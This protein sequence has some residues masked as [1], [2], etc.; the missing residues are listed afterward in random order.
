MHSITTRT[1]THCSLARLPAQ[2][3]RF[4]LPMTD[5]TPETLAASILTQTM[6]ARRAEARRERNK[7]SAKVSRARKNQE[8][9]LLQ[10]QV[11]VYQERIASLEAQLAAHNIPDPAGKPH[12]VKHNVSIQ[13]DGE[14]VP[15]KKKRS[16]YV[17][18]DTPPPFCGPLPA[19]TGMAEFV[20]SPPMPRGFECVVPGLELGFSEQAMVLPPMVLASELNSCMQDCG[21]S[22]AVVCKDTERTVVAMFETLT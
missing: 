7:E 20:P 11:Q 3:P 2:L 12:V 1:N 4:V 6:M 19:L 21:K 9:L 22:E 17:R 8:L 10:D 13:T 5:A 16:K 15:R 18:S 14:G